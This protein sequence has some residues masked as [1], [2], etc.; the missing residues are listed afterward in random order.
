[1]SIAIRYTQG[2]EMLFF[3]VQ[4][5]SDSVQVMNDDSSSKTL[6]FQVG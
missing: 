5:R 3:P 2:L 6:R 1:M 4:S